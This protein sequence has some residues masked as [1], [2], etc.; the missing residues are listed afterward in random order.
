MNPTNNDC[1]VNLFLVATHRTNNIS[2]LLTF[3]LSYLLTYLLTYLRTYLL[4]YLLTYLR[5]SYLQHTLKAKSRAENP[6]RRDRK[7]APR[8]AR[9]D[10]KVG[11]F[12]N[13]PRA[14]QPRS[15]AVRA[16][17]KRAA[18]IYLCYLG[19]IGLGPNL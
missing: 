15:G 12:R 10:D 14:R 2:Y 11:K 17:A 7:R 1:W 6:L 9:V 18:T 3:L 4:T 5:E 8:L 19:R 16:A 13:E